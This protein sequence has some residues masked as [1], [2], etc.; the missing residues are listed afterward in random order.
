MVN[1][2]DK[3]MG[4]VERTSAEAGAGPWVPGLK[5]QNGYLFAADFDGVKAAAFET[6]PGR[7]A[8]TL[9][10]ETLVTV[11]K[12]ASGLNVI[13]EL[14]LRAA[15]EGIITVTLIGPRGRM[16]KIFAFIG[17]PL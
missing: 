9:E 14:Q 12:V 2:F 7:I 6:A 11:R 5:T 1:R 3:A 17:H 8:F 13:L 15:D 10:P 4:I 16:K